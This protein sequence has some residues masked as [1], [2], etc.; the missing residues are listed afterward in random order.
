MAEVGGLLEH[1]VSISSVR[2]VV[3]NSTSPDSKPTMPAATAAMSR[4]LIGSLQM[5]YFASMPTV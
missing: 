5:P 1:N 2:P 4:P 3:R